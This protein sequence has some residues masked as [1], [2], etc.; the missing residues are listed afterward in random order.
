MAATNTPSSEPGI[1]AE[2]A[3]PSTGSIHFETFASADGTKMEY[4]IALPDNFDSQ[5]EY[6]IL[7]ALPPG[8]QGKDLVQALL[9]RYWAEGINRGWVVLSPAA[10]GGVLFF[11][12]SE[13]LIPEF[14]AE[15]ARTYK[16]EGGQYHLAGISNGGLSAFRIIGNNPELFKSLLVLPGFP[17]TEA[18]QQKLSSLVNIP[19]AMF[20]GGEDTGWLEAMQDTEKTLTQLGGKVTLKVLPGEGHILESLT[21]GEL[22][23]LLESFR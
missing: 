4:A 16:P 23:D 10:P 15:T 19:V 8:G 18:D 22:F 14:L 5:K 1:T 6:P 12:G 3:T 20:V 9:D 2:A 17:Q 7:L 11:S 13:R 21:A